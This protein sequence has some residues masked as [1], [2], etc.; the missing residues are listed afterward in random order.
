MAECAAVLS[1]TI[2]LCLCVLSHHSSQKDKGP[3]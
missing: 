3:G 1:D 2:W